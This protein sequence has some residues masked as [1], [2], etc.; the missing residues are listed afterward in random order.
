MVEVSITDAQRRWSELDSP[1][2]QAQH[3]G[4]PAE[5]A[6]LLTDVLGSKAG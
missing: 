6:T 2:R 1:H 5:L 3:D 4:R